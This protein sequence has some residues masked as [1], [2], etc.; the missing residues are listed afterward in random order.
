M[1]R[2]CAP[3]SSRRLA[4]EFRSAIR[5]RT[6]S[7]SA[8]FG[9]ISRY[10]VRSVAAS[11]G[12]SLSSAQFAWSK[13]KVGLPAGRDPRFFNASHRLELRRVFLAELDDVMVSG[14]GTTEE[15]GFSGSR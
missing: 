13:L 12:L 9:D 5:N 1:A 2:T 8:A 7:A 11:A 15:P 3:F 6:R 4:S 10:R 14:A